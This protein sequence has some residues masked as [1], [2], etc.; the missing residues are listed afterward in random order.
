[1]VLNALCACVSVIGAAFIHGPYLRMATSWVDRHGSKPQRSAY[2][3]RLAAGLMLALGAIG[4][5]PLFG[6]YE[7]VY[8]SLTRLALA[9]WVPQI[10][11]A[12]LFIREDRSD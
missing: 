7:H 5:I 10:I 9:L 12:T 1:M 2:L 3:L 6:D 4:A 11:L 8:S